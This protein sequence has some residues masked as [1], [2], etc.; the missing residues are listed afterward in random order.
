M[1]T[2]GEASMFHE[3]EIAEDEFKVTG[4]ALACRR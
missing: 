4:L 1:I 2:N 3:K